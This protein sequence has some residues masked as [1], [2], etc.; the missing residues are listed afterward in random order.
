MSNAVKITKAVVP[1]AGFGTRFLP[2]TKALPKEMLPVVDKPVV[3]YIVEELVASGITDIIFV[4]GQNK[5]AVEDHF[6]FHPELEGWLAKAGKREALKRIR[7]VAELANFIYIRQKGVYG[8]G[9]PVLNARHLLQDE[10]FVYVFSDDLVLSREPFTKDMISAYQKAPG[11]YVGV[12]EVAASEVS[13]YGVIEPKADGAPNEIRS[14]IEKPELDKAPSRLAIFGR[15]ILEPGIF[16]ALAAIPLGKGGELWLT[17]G[18][19]YLLRRGQKAYFQKIEA[20]EWHTT[21]D[22]I[23]YLKTIRAF[24]LSRPDYRNEVKDIFS[25]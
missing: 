7:D 2:V 15:Y 18:I 24:A 6:D 17:D 14:I 22:P 11:I 1:V 3:Q 8:N 19:E 16:D 23:S 9:T 5:R 10:P 21:G 20:G 13:K 4:T 12:Q 25:P